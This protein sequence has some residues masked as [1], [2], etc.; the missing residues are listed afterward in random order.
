MTDIVVGDR[1][2]SGASLKL[3]LVPER[4]FNALVGAMWM[5]SGSLMAFNPA[6]PHQPHDRSR[7]AMVPCVGVI[8]IAAGIW[9]IVR[10]VRAAR[11]EAETPRATASLNRHAAGTAFA[12]SLKMFGLFIAV[13][14]IASGGLW[15]GIRAG[16]LSVMGLASSILGPA[17]LVVVSRIVLAVRER[18]RRTREG[19]PS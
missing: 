9:F 12:D 3:G 17:L 19:E 16:L 7:A 6:P 1:A 5:I 10:A 18:R 11:T 2:P 13:V 15:W 14:G 8:V 4:L